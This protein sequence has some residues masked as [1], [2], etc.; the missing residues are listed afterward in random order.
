MT[1]ETWQGP[2]RAKGSGG[3]GERR[4]LGGGSWELGATHPTA[5]AWRWG[6]WEQELGVCASDSLCL[7]LFLCKMGIIVRTKGAKNRKAWNSAS[8]PGELMHVTRRGWGH[9]YP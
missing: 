3:G 5:G 1:A 8:S 9:P 6:R 4:G 2:S 7:S